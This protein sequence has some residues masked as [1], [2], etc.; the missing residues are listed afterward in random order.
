M[1]I[2]LLKIIF[3]ILKKDSVAAHFNTFFFF[4]FFYTSNEID[5]KIASFLTSIL[6][7]NNNEMEKRGIEL[8]E[9]NILLD[10]MIAI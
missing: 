4:C 9:E 10:F 8:S 2:Y 5:L 6:D 3:D 1:K 7:T